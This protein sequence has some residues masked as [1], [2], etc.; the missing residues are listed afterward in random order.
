MIH[1]RIIA[2]PIYE[3]IQCQVFQLSAMSVPMTK[4]FER[5]KKYI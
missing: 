1:Q 5:S 3:A 2:S 4:R